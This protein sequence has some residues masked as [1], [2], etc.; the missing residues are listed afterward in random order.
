M[1]EV[2]ELYV[3]S[4]QFSYFGSHPV[5]TGAYLKCRVGD[6]IALLGRNGCGKST[7]LKIIFGSI[8]A[9][10]SYILVNGKRINRA[11]RS[12]Q[13]GYLSQDSFL[14]TNEKVSDLI[15]L[16]VD[17][18]SMRNMVLNDVR[19]QTLQ[20]KKVYQLSGG[21]RRYLEVYLL[22]CQ[23]SDF[24]LLDEPFSGLEPIYKQHITALILKFK[25]KKGF[26]IS[27]HN[28]RDV[29]DI[30]TQVVL[31]QNGTCRQIHH[32]KELEF[33]YVPIGTFDKD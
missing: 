4:V 21:E 19:I 15:R 32:K 23:P 31:L 30:A 17:D 11:Y 20:D 27:D 24:L 22:I 2:K 33:F 18:R 12:G 7:F 26:V 6:V 8:K 14:P 25:D 16:L 1:D 13:V 28:Y 3:D 10:H 5:L 29:L 9:Q